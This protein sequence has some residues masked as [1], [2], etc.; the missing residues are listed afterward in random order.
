M[1]S[2]RSNSGSILKTNYVKHIRFWE[3]LYPGSWGSPEECNI[4]KRE[5]NGSRP[6]TQFC[7]GT[8]FY[9]TKGL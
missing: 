3:T 6:I 5:K 8:G 7:L 4:D 1:F 2:V 9:I